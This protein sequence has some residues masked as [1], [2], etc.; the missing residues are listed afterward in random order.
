MGT[1]FLKI[2]ESEDALEIIQKLFD[3][4]YTLQSEEIAVE[5]AVFVGIFHNA[6]NGL[7]ADGLQLRIPPEGQQVSHALDPF[8]H[9]RVPENVGLIPAFFLPLA[10]EGVKA[11]GFGKAAVDGP[12]G[13]VPDHVLL[14]LPKTVMDGHLG[15][16]DVFHKRVL[17]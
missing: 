9:V 7:V 2:K 11:V 17:L 16:G 15:K 5:V 3:K 10:A 1:E 4:Y 14:D 13:G 12:D 6:G 8:G